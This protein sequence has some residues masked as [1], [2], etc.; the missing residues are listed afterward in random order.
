[1][2]TE[3]MIEN[4]KIRPLVPTDRERVYAFFRALGEEGGRFFNLN[5]YNERHTYAFLDGE[6][7]NHIYWAAVADTPAGEEIVGLGFLYK[8]NTGIPWLGVGVAE[9][10]QGKHLGGRLMAVAEGWAE[11]AGAGGILLTT[12][13]ENTRAQM[14]YKHRGYKNI[15]NYCN[16]EM[17]Y[18]LA[19][20]SK[21]QMDNSKSPQS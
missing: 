17:L 11:S 2:N 15:G 14:L 1:M 21:A 3:T 10:W 19:F 13:R 12:A 16:G 7:Q 4:I 5:E 8:I 18:L 20:E 6:R 9:K